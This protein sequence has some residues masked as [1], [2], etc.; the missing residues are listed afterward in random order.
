LPARFY[1]LEATR[2]VV[3][4]VRGAEALQHAEKLGI[5]ATPGGAASV[6]A[7]DAYGALIRL[8]SLVAEGYSRA[9]AA[10]DC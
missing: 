5:P 6:H 8:E 3:G 1:A 10:I 4:E 2:I 9:A 7:N